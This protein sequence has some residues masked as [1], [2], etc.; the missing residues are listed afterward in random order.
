MARFAV[1][2]VRGEKDDVM[3]S[4]QIRC[5]ATAAMLGALLLAAAV[6]GIAQATTVTFDWVPT[7]ENPASG[8]STAHGTLTLNIGSWTLSPIAGNG[9]GPN[10]YTSGT[11]MTATIVGLSYTFGNG[12]TVGLGNLSTTLIG[13]PNS[14]APPAATIWATSAIDTPATG[15]QAP[16]APGP[17]YYLITQFSVSGTVAGVAFMI[18]NNSGTAGAN[19]QNGIGNGG[20]T[21]GTLPGGTADGGYWKLETAPPVPVPAALPL[22]LGGLG[23]LG[24]LTRRRPVPAA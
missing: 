8:T 5:S 2:T 6:P 17:G 4:F 1:R 9:L 16:A 11:A 22:L 15:A 10:Y 13:V 14:G 23:M 21:Y 20:N 24:G 7:T 18:G 19:V 3:K 12:V